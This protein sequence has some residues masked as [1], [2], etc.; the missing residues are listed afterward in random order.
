MKSPNWVG[1]VGLTWQQDR[2][3]VLAPRESG[4]P[5]F[6]GTQRDPG[7]YKKTGE[8]TSSQPR[9]GERRAGEARKR[10]HRLQSGAFPNINSLGSSEPERE[11]KIRGGK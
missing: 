3:R 7:E 5:G 6:V 11:L 9:R 2:E 1:T 4:C 10:C 8:G